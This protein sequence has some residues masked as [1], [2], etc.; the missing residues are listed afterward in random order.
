MADRLPEIGT[1]F[2]AKYDLSPEQSEQVERYVSRLEEQV[3][4]VAR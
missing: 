2:R 4:T 3:M 1:Y